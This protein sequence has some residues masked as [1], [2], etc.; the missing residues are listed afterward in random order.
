MSDKPWLT[1]TP[2][3]VTGGTITL[4]ADPTGQPVDQPLIAEV[5]VKS[6]DASVMNE[7]TIRV[8][9]WVGNTDPTDF[10][11]AAPQY[12]VVANPVEPYVYANSKGTDVSVYNVYSGALVNT[13]HNVVALAGSMAVSTDGTLLFVSDD[14]NHRVVELDAATG[15]EIQR[16]PWL[17]SSSLGIAYARPN[18]QPVLLLGDGSTF[19]VGT[20]ESRRLSAMVS[21]RTAAWPVSVWMG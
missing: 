9:L 12:F 5:L 8:G 1:V 20:A 17:G 7:E 19:D 10:S 2:S 11:Y 3:G 14:T 13:L 4:T 21:A 16:F 15:A 6:S 18:A